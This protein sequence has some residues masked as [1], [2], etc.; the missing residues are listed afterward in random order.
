MYTSLGAMFD[1]FAGYCS[2]LLRAMLALCVPAEEL[3]KIFCLL[4]FVDGLLP[5]V[6]SEIYAAIWIVSILLEL[7]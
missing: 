7:I 4:A 1:I 3:G 6:V 2:A 5:F